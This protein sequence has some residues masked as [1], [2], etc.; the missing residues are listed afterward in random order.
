[1]DLEL[2]TG[3]VHV[4]V[5]GEGP[6]V[7]WIHGFPFTGESWKAQAQ[8]IPGYK[9]VV[10]DLPGYGRSAPLADGGPLTMDVAADVCAQTLER[11]G[12][13]RAT[14]VGLSMGGYVLFA[15]VRR[16]PERVRA[17]IFCDTKAGADSEDGKKG[18]EKFAE[19]VLKEGPGWAAAQLIPK[20][21]VDP[22]GPVAKQLQAMIAAQPAAS[23]AATQRG[24][25]ARPDSTP[26]M[27]QVAVPTLVIC[28]GSDAL[29]PPAE[30]K[31]IV[32]GIQG[33]SYAEIA[34]AAHV[35]NLEKPDAFNEAVKRFLA[36][37]GRP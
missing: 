35:P 6:A 24:M 19:N 20:L 21:V 4:E 37:H 23:M 25:A 8:G 12:I 31:K 16:A 13:A 36:E 22:A 18:R 5:T 1:M 9:H 17:C 29:I 34:G 10:P 3:R 15:L 28:G 14:A 26:T 27:A 7:L 2:R 11:L 30:S 33:A 32:D